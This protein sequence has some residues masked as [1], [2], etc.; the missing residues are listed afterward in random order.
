[1]MILWFLFL[2]HTGEAALDSVLHLERGR[3]PE[4]VRNRTMC[5][6]Y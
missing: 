2:H 1:M 6:Y 3:A 4:I 5:A